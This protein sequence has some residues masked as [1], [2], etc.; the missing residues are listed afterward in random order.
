[1]IKLLAIAIL[2]SLAGVLTACAASTPAVFGDPMHESRGSTPA[3]ASK[4]AILGFHGPVYRG[5]EAFAP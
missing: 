2:A 4:A 5:G 1:M 3:G